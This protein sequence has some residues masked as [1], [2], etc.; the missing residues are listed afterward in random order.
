MELYFWRNFRNFINIAFNW[1]YFGEVVN[2]TITAKKLLYE[3]FTLATLGLFQVSFGNFW[4]ML[5]LPEIQSFT[6]LFL[7][8]RCFALFIS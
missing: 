8:L 4:G 6:L 1:F 5:K 7:F 3:Q 2:N